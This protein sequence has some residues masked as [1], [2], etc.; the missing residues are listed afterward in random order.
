MTD[1]FSL[2][3]LGVVV[4]D[5][6]AHD[7]VTGWTWEGEGSPPPMVVL[8]GEHAEGGGRETMER[9]FK[10]WQISSAY[11]VQRETGLQDYV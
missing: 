5:G 9:E 8:W 2:R 6:V 3:Y 4:D 7:I 10:I 11:T 1:G